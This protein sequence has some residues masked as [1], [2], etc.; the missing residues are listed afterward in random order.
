MTDIHSSVCLLPARREKELSIDLRHALAVP[1]SSRLPIYV[2]DSAVSSS[3][4]RNEASE[5]DSDMEGDEGS[6]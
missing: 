6:C 4:Y 5:H 2:D 1:A 3:W